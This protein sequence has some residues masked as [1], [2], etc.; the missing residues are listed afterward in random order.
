MHK[1]SLS[2]ILR[3]ADARQPGVTAGAGPDPKVPC[4]PSNPPWKHSEAAAKAGK[5]R[6]LAERGMGVTGNTMAAE[7]RKKG[8]NR[9]LRG[10]ENY[11]HSELLAQL[12]CESLPRNQIVQGKG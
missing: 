10:F 2:Q 8:H 1:G 9:S 6:D 5:V 11:H 4:N 3:K 7:A 12:T